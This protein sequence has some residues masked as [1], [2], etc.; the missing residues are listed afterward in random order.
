MRVMMN[1]KMMLVAAVML[2]VMLF[3]T[4]TVFADEST[5]GATSLQ[6][7]IDNGKAITLEDM[8]N[9]AIEDEYHAKTEYALIID[10]YDAPRT[11]T[12]IIKAEERHIQWL[13]PLFQA[14]GIDVPEDVSADFVVLPE[15]LTAAYEIG[16]EAEIL[17]IDMYNVFLEQ[18]LPQD[19]EQVFTALRN[20]SENHLKAF[21]RKTGSF[22]PAGQAGR[23]GGN[24]F[25]RNR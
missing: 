8:L 6:E 11:F 12:N 2:M 4:M 22:A 25:G 3:G 7:A 21:E 20:A 16:V 18:D 14:Y 10:A 24:G 17:N 1:R 5:Y 23:N 13:L 19:V 9:Y 15:S